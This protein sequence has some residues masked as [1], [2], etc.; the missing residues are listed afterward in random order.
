MRVILGYLLQE[1]IDTRFIYDEGVNDR[2]IS[3]IREYIPSE[4][5]RTDVL[6]VVSENTELA[7]SDAVPGSLPILLPEMPECEVP[8]AFSPIITD[9]S[10]DY[11][12]VVQALRDE[13]RRME[14]LNLTLYQASCCG[15]GLEELINIVGNYT[16]NH[17]YIADMSFKVLA[18]TD[19]PYMNEMSA[20]WRYQVLH[21]Y[22]PVHV[23][24]GLIENGEF[25][26]LNGYHNAAHHYSKSF[27]VPFATRNI[28]LKN[29]P[30]AHLFVVDMITRPC[31][32]DLVL[33]QILGDF[34]EQNIY[35]LSQ[36]S[37]E[38]VSGNFEAFFNDVL[39]GGCTDKDLIQSQISL[40]G[41]ESDGQY[42]IAIIDIK[43]RDEGIQKTRMYEIESKT[44]WM[45][46]RHESDLVIVA[47]VGSGS[48]GTNRLSLK[49]MTERYSVQTV[50]GV[51]FRGLLNLGQQY[52]FLN[53][54][55]ELSNIPGVCSGQNFIESRNLAIHYYV[56]GLR[57]DSVSRSLC[58]PDAELLLAH[59]NEN[60]T[61]LFG[62]YLAFLLNDRNLVRTA[63]E[64]NIHRNTLVYRIEKIHELIHTDE[65]D[66]YQKMH[67]ILSMLILQRESVENNM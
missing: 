45:C 24:K 7:N 32:K 41:W 1:V 56:E 60:G 66:Y 34:L 4:P 40:M 62:T 25:E 11:R 10:M 52:D 43:G 64:L 18:Y 26:A 48:G 54:I 37:P 65:E 5:A 44:K 50:V 67:L 46:F 15:S 6:Y 57:C 19:R 23:M 33:A 22:L 17:I 8:P 12:A 53:K 47:S 58:S 39:V 42:G 28:F 30:Q 13:F 27:Y 35:I 2:W 20:S 51:P 63:K 59:D 16:P 31:Y 9:G 38:R 14:D 21:G 29:R 49:E 3:E 55:R 36:F 61:E